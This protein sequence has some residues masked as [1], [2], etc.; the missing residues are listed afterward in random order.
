MRATGEPFKIDNPERFIEEFPPDIVFGYYDLPKIPA[1]VATAELTFDIGTR[2]VLTGEEIAT[3]FVW[4]QQPAP[5]EWKL[6]AGAAW[7][8]AQEQVRE[9]PQDAPPEPVKEK[10]KGKR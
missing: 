3:K 9:Q 5:A 10:K 2:S 7:E 4:K 8:G 6:P 1:D